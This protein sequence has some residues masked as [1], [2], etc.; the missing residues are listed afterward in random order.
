VVPI[1]VINLVIT[2]TV[3]NISIPGHLGGLVVGAMVGA[4]LAYAPAKAR[5]V[6]QAVGCGAVFVLLLLLAVARSAA[7]LG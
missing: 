6:V 7:L 5:T 2:L 1:L 3:P 4:I